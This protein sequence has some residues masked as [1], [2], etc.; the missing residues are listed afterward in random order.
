[1]EE[2][3]AIIDSKRSEKEDI[4]LT[5]QCLRKANLEERVETR[6][7]DESKVEEAKKRLEEIKKEETSVKDVVESLKHELENVQEAKEANELA[8]DQIRSSSTKDDV[9]DNDMMD[10]D[11]NLNSDFDYD[12]YEHY[13]STIKLTRQDFKALSRKVEEATTA[14]D[15]KVATIMISCLKGQENE[16]F[17]DLYVVIKMLHVL[18]M[19]ISYAKSSLIQFQCEIITFRLGVMNPSIQPTQKLKLAPF[20]DNIDA[21]ISPN[22]VNPMCSDVERVLAQF[23]ALFKTDDDI[24]PRKES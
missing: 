8:D 24:K 12:T 7:L 3:Q 14:A 10:D 13:N 20:M 11:T 22:R 1:M 17:E 19:F 23:L 5:I 2:K 15:I 4:E 9:A 21:N 6:R 16:E 18:L